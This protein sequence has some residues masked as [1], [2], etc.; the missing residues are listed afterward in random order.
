MMILE[1]CVENFNNVPEVIKK[2][3]HRIELCDNLSVGGTTVSHGVAVRTIQ[4]CKI[5]NVKVMA[6]IRPRGG[7]FIYSSEEIAIMQ[8]DIDHLKGLGVDGVVFG[9]LTDTE[10]ID[11]LAISTLLDCSKGL[12]VAFHMA[13]DQINTNYQLKA[14]DWLASQG[15][16][17]IL[18]H[19]GPS[20]TPINNN[21][22]RLKEYL[23]YA[24][25]R[26]TIMPGGGI[27]NHNLDYIKSNLK[28]NEV[29]GTRIV[30]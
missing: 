22:T 21:I 29:H 3:A 30:G 8:N 15:V 2:G 4:Y 27:T 14:I 12:E 18:T 26:I 10:W 16:N 19:G 9:C 5:N 11:E 25:D 17:R 1:A 20:S 28:I 6:M 23:E 13:F 7:D 24:S